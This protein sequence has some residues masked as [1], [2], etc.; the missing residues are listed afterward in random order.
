VGVAGAGAAHTAYGSAFSTEHG[1]RH[2][3]HNNCQAVH[4]ATRHSVKVK[5]NAVATGKPTR[6]PSLPPRA[7]CSS[8][9][10]AQA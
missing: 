4:T 9:K 1:A 3:A 7:V 8:F 2:G 5:V 6:D 10:E